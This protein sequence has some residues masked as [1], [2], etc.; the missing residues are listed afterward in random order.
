MREVILQN[1]TLKWRRPQA[2][3]AATQA[4]MYKSMFIAN[5]AMCGVQSIKAYELSA[6][7]G[8][9]YLFQLKIRSSDQVICIGLT[10]RPVLQKWV[11][12][13]QA[14]VNQAPIESLPSS[15]S[16]ALT[17]QGGSS[18]S[19]NAEEGD[20]DGEGRESEFFDVLGNV[21]GDGSGGASGK[22]GELKGYLFKRK[23]NVLPKGFASR[24]NYRKFWC[25][26]RENGIFLFRSHLEAS[27]G[28]MPLDMIDIRN[29]Y[30]V[31]EAS[32]ANAPENS[33]EIVTVQ[34]VITFCA[35]DDETQMLWM[36]AIGDVL[37]SRA[38]AIQKVSPGAA[39]GGGVGGEGGD[40]YASIQSAIVYSGGLT[41]KSVNLYTGFVTWRDR[42]IVITRGA[43]SYYR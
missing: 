18:G 11:D 17:I 25:I 41:M 13:F 39:V 42:F 38:A 2:S 6:S 33:I 1:G 16:S 5:A 14:L 28:V 36:D 7:S 30:E 40:R 26:L 34:K 21:D 29:V 43:M 22:V 9:P 35:D 3:N 8:Q 37:E 10:S 32:D 20:E 15:L 27:S 19:G 23:D 31:R 12:A 24:S 4:E